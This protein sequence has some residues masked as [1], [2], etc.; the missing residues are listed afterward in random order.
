MEEIKSEASQSIDNNKN[1]EFS[2]DKFKKRNIE[3]NSKNSL[4]KAEKNVKFSKKLVVDNRDQKPENFSDADHEGEYENSI[5]APKQANDQHLLDQLNRY[6]MQDKSIFYDEGKKINT[7]NCTNASPDE[8]D[9]SNQTTKDD[10]NISDS[11]HKFEGVL[12]QRPIKGFVWGMGHQANKKKC[13]YY[14]FYFFDMS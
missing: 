11:Q 10:E 3:L 1:K 8:K 6:I 7:V 12:V 14:F 4:V 9:L 2:F 13:I 5:S